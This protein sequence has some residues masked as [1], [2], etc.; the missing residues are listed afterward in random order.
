MARFGDTSNERVYARLHGIEVE[1]D[2]ATDIGPIDCPRCHRDTPRH[3]D[4][5]VWCHFA[6]TPNATDEVAAQD[7]RLFCS[8]AQASDTANASGDEVTSD[9]VM[10]A[11]QL[12]QEHPELRRVLLQDN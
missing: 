6:L 2:E 12:L 10:A 11:R 4:F 1:E 9:D 7:D 8:V 5:C 3:E